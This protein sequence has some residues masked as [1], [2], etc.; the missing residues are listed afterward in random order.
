VSL[1]YL[2]QNHHPAEEL[3]EAMQ[4]PCKIQPRN[5]SCQLMVALI[6]LLII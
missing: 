4:L 2:I 6:D 1:H 3:S 5:Y